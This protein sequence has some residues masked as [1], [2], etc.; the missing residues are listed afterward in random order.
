MLPSQY[1]YYILEMGFYVS[2]LLSLSF[3]V[4]RKVRFLI[5]KGK[6]RF[7]SVRLQ[8]QLCWQDFKEQVIHHTATL[9]LLSF[10]W[11]S[12]YIRIGTLVM[13]VHDCSDILLEVSTHI[14]AWWWLV[15]YV[16]VHNYSGSLS[17]L[18]C[19][20]SYITIYGSNKFLM[21]CVVW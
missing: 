4:K 3:D 6:K 5:Q 13:A 7:S 12:N 19:F 1:W 9:T 21:W 18:P 14:F 8:W 17:F 2:L 15:S 11:I 20:P 10:S 16:S